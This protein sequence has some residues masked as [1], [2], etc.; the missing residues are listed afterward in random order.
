MT[1]NNRGF[2]LIEI[3]VALLVLAI[4][5]TVIF[6]GFSVGFRN[7]RT[8]DDFT[9]AVLIAQAK[10]APTGVSEPLSTGVTSGREQD[11][12]AWT[13]TIDRA[14]VAPGDSATPN[15]LQPFFVAVDVV[16]SDGG[17]ERTVSLS[18]LRLATQ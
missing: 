6:E 18:T 7:A 4:A 10:L 14:E 5:S 16:W 9:Q 3:V 12:Y 17:T 2:T 11:K 13:V 15:Q 1:R 8:A